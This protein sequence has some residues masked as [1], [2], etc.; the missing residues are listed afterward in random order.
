MQAIRYKKDKQKN[1][2]EEQK[3]IYKVVYSI[4]K[5]VIFVYFSKKKQI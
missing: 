3:D 5:V 4:Q 1:T 2:K